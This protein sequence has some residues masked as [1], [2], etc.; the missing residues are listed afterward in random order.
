MP[1]SIVDAEPSK[2]AARE[3]VSSLE[4]STE[5]NLMPMWCAEMAGLQMC[6]LQGSYANGGLCCHLML[7]SW[8][9]LAS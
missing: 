5:A 9:S 4:G 2:K 7:H 3:Q 8:P 6:S 1:K